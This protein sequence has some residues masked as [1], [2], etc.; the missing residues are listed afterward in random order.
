[1]YLCVC[2]IRT[3]VRTYVPTYLPTYLPRG[4]VQKRF[5]VDH[6]S[7]TL[8]SVTNWLGKVGHCVYDLLGQVRL[9]LV[10]L[11]LVRFG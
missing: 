3:Y 7:F 6:S 1:M 5:F 2:I 4:Y 9:G 10:K 8:T 11:G